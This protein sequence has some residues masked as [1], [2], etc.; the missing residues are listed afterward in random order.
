MI[1]YNII[2]YIKF[3]KKIFYK[4]SFYDIKI[5]IIIYCVNPFN[6]FIYYF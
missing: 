3:L 5:F 1:S 2:N 6:P 4:T